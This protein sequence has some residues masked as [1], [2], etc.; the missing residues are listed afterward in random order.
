VALTADGKK[1]LVAPAQV[2]VGLRV[3]PRPGQQLDGQVLSVSPQTLSQR[4]ARVERALKQDQEAQA[5]IRTLRELL[6][7]NT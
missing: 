1:G 7:G 5:W 6:T 3:V 2:D 4:I